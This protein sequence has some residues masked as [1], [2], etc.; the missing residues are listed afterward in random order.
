M[1]AMAD[2]TPQP[3]Q[4]SA[5]SC[6]W[7]STI[8]TPGTAT[9]PNCGAVLEGDEETVLPGV[10]AVD[11]K[12]LRGETKP[13]QRSR[14]LS[15]INGDYDEPEGGPVD[16]SAIAP[17]DPAVQREMR[18]LAIEAEVANLQ[19]EVEARRI[20]AVV[21]ELEE[22]GDQAGAEAMVEAVVAED[23][24][25]DAEVAALGGEA[26]TAPVTPP[27][28]PGETD[29]EASSDSGPNATSANDTPA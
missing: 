24:R 3:E 27:E 10:T 17:P 12:I 23:A 11:D 25:V 15:W 19:A 28:A 5:N 2:P 20:E 7:C 21:D 8:V 16:P 6:P 26:A 29:A 1:T 22:T 13:Q 18:R 4:P 9:C 14:L